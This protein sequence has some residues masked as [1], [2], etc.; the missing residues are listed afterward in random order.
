MAFKP[1]FK[2]Y[3]TDG[4]SGIQAA[5]GYLAATRD[6]KGQR[7]HIKMPLSASLEVPLKCGSRNQSPH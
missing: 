6:D 5:K 7:G 3:C 4:A 1:S 2:N